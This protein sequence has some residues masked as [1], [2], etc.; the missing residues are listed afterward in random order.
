M[1]PA[2][3]KV[4]YNRVSAQLRPKCCMGYT[5]SKKWNKT[6]PICY[7]SEFKFNWTSCP[8]CVDLT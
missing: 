4:N 2:S 3:R 5:Y 6:K 7:L 1:K 8:I